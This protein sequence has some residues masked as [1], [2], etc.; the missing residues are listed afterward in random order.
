MERVIMK[1]TKS[2]KQRAK[3]HRERKKQYIQILEDKVKNLEK[4]NLSLKQQLKQ[5]KNKEEQTKEEDKNA[6][7]SKIAGQS[8]IYKYNSSLQEYEDYY[9]N[10]LAKKILLDPTQVRYSEIEQ[11]AE[12]I[13][14]YGDKRREYL[15]NTFKDFLDNIM[16]PE[17]KTIAAACKNLSLSEAK[18][19]SKLKKRTRKY[20]KK[21]DAPNPTDFLFSGSFRPKV[22]DF[23]EN[24]GKKILRYFKSMKQLIN[25]LVEIRNQIFNLQT[26]SKEF[27]ESPEIM[28]YTKEDASSIFKLYFELKDTKMITSHHLWDI[29]IKEHSEEKYEEGELT[30]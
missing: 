13:C 17:M 9:F 30:E 20:L 8:C 1:Q 29:P 21:L 25:K 26:E 5:Q 10:T 2:S 27:L 19:R 3:E 28:T 6:T 16:N 12:K 23:F 18:R 24:S 14:D 7:S 4:E 15:K 11:A 22:S